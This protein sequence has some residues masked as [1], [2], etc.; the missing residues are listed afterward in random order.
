LRYKAFNRK[1]RKGT[2][3]V[4]KEK[5]PPVPKFRQARRKLLAKKSKTFPMEGVNGQTV[6]I[7]KGR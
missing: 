6:S 7:T 2:R 1:G 4:R 3:K 5:L